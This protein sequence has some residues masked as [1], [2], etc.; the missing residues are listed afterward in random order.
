[1][2]VVITG[3]NGHLGV[4]LVRALIAKGRHTRCLVHVNRQAIEG[5]DTGIVQGDVC[6]L[7]SLCAAFEGAEVVYHLAA[8]ISIMMSDWPRLEQVNVI[9]TRNV[10]DACLRCGVRRL[11]HFSSIHALVQEP[12]CTPVDESRALVASRGCPP[13]DRSKAA[14]EKEVERGIKSGLV[15]TTSV[16]LPYGQV[17][18][19]RRGRWRDWP[20]LSGRWPTCCPG[21]GPTM[22]GIKLISRTIRF[23][24]FPAP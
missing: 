19:W 4:N 11:V 10:V 23:L 3:A 7:D 8:N 9:G 2:T 17:G 1:M 15:P 14:G 22:P 20:S 24:R 13:Y 5:L 12:M 21:P 6:D 18:L 16:R